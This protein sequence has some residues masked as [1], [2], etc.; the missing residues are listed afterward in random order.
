MFIVWKSETGAQDVPPDSIGRRSTTLSRG[1]PEGDCSIDSS[2]DKEGMVCAYEPGVVI[3]MTKMSLDESRA[4]LFGRPNEPNRR[5]K[6][7]IVLASR[8]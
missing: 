7:A 2:S 5:Q 1:L 4:M 6:R 8:R 3:T